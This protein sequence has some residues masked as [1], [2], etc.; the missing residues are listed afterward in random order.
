MD[1]NSVIAWGLVVMGIL[2]VSGWIALSYKTGTSTGT[3]IPI[4]ITSGLV[5]VLT[6]KNMA[7]KTEGVTVEET[8][9]TT[10]KGKT[11]LRGKTPI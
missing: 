8:D 10:K 4:A 3:E 11:E 1:M 2:A 5:G 6:G 7:E 9:Q